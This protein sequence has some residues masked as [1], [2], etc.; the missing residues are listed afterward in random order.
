M[1]AIIDKSNIE[2]KVKAPQSKSQGIRLI[3]LSLLTKIK[4][5]NYTPSDDIKMALNA[6]DAIRSKTDYIYVGGSATT[7]RMLIPIVVA[8]KM[9][10]TIDGDESLRRRPISSIIKALK[11]AKF[12]S[13]SLPITIESNGLEEEIEIEGWESSQYISGLIYAYH[14]IGG[15]KIKIIPPISS[16]SYIEMTIDLFNRF[17]SDVKLEGNTV[18]VNPKPLREYEGEIPG[19]Y[20]LSSF[21]AIASIISQRKIEINGLY[22]PPEYFGDH[23]IIDI[24]ANIG[25]KSYYSKHS[26]FVEYQGSIS[27]VEID[28]NDI[29]DLSTSLSAILSIADGASKLSGVERLKIKESNRI[30][31]I[32]DTLEAFGVNAEYKDQSIIIRGS[33]I[34]RGS[35][36]CPND[37]RIAMLAG[38]LAIKEGGEIEKAECV[39][40]SNPKFW[41]DLISLGGKITLE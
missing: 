8:L 41:E 20:A 15:G 33:Q 34:K 9:K 16:K 37:H 22:D 35:I 17:G 36:I 19:D 5:Y 2:G 12:S 30:E 32:I 23:K 31:T 3:F 29:P 6:V 13:A 21:Y 18:Y 40:K 1:K 39:N 14:L 10:V 11:K 24:L 26:W 4:L 28:I 7:L 25:V 27:P 38:D